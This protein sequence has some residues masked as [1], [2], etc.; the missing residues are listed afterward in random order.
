[1]GQFSFIYNENIHTAVSIWG[2]GIILA[3][4]LGGL[5]AIWVIEKY[6]YKQ[7]GLSVSE[8]MYAI[9]FRDGKV[10]PT[11]VLAKTM[12]SAITIGTGCSV[13]REGPVF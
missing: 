5:I 1:M 7:R 6:A 8:I 9:F 4:I 10:S 3:P 13:G 12:A 11:I 2:I